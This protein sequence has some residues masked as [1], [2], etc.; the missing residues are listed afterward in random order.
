M[1]VHLELDAWVKYKQIFLFVLPLALAPSTQSLES[2]PEN[3]FQRNVAKHEESLSPQEQLARLN[4][5]FSEEA[6]VTCAAHGDARA[7]ELFLAAGMSP[8][9]K[10]QDGFTPLMWSAGQ[11]QGS[12]TRLPDIIVARYAGNSM[13]AA[14]AYFMDAWSIVRPLL[15]G[16]VAVRPRIFS[17]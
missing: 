11:G 8:N 7:I 6:F 4:V 15:T 1:P 16:L 3:P 12:V 5:P 9:A 17:T 13:E 10:N 2:R 14:A